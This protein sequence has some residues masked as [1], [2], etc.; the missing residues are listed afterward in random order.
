MRI[1]DRNCQT[2][3]NSR[4]GSI[5]SNKSEEL[6]NNLKINKLRE[7]FELLD[8]KEIGVLECDDLELSN[9]D[10]ETLNIFIPIFE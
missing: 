8:Y 1:R 7:V 6:F 4:R 9:L 3:N 2:Q 10:P 5:V